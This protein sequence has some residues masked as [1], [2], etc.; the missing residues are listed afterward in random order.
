MKIPV[1]INNRDLL[2]WPKAMV[3]RIKG[4]DDVGEIWIVDNNS[5]YPP[6]IEWYDNITKINTARAI[7][8]LGHTGAWD[9]GV[10]KLLDS[11]YYVITDSD[12]DLSNTPDN[13]LL[14]LLEREKELKLGKIGL[15]L[16]WKKVK[17]ESPYYNHMMNYEKPR[18]ERSS[19][20]NDIFIDVAID[21]TFALY[22]VPHYFIGGGSTVFPYVARHLPWEFTVEEREKDEEFMYYIK[23]ASNSSSYKTFLRL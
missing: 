20:K 15:G 18:W 8:N 19:I 23:N 9:S 11:P 21:T 4:Y 2:A 14:Y 10:V 5:S 1:I 6:L 3:E 12:L 13:T 17:P 22:S 7:N 16:D